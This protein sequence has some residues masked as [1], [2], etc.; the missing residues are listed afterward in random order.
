MALVGFVSK[1]YHLRAERLYKLYA[2]ARQSCATE[3]LVKLV[4]QQEFEKTTNS[5]LTGRMSG[6]LAD[7]YRLNVVL[8]SYS[9]FFPY[10]LLVF[11]TVRKSSQNVDLDKL[12]AYLQTAEQNV[13]AVQEEL[14]GRFSK[15]LTMLGNSR[16]DMTAH[17]AEIG[18]GL[19]V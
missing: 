2:G 7:A 12:S 14:Q 18:S 10:L 15:A 1:H 8:V 9:M 13:F 3:Q 11:Q 19:T 17:L 16:D 6:I 4:A 5:T